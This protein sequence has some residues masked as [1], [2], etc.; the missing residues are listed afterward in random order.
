MSNQ[1]ETPEAANFT[2]AVKVKEPKREFTGITFDTT[3]SPWKIMGLTEIEVDED[4]LRKVNEKNPVSE[5]EPEG[6]WLPKDEW[7]TN[8]ILP[9]QEVTICYPSASGAHMWT[10]PISFYVQTKNVKEHL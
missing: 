8:T 2:G 3:S 1:K 7:T 6:V 5:K 4:L 9:G 10:Q